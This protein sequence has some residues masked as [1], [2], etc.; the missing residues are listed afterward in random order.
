VR[1]IRLPTLAA[2]AFIGVGCISHG[3]P[4]VGAEANEGTLR[5]CLN[6]DLPPYSVRHGKDGAGFDYLIAE[7]LAKRLGKQ[8]AV[9]WFESKLDEDSSTRIEAN[10][11]LSDGRCDLLGGY[12]LV[13]DELGKPGL[14]TARL[15]GFAGAGAADRRRRVTLGTLAAT[16][17]YHFA[18]LTVVL[19]GKAAAKPITGLADLDGVNIGTEAGTFADAILM[20]F[21]HGR[22][23]SRITHLVPGRGELLPELEKGEYDATLIPLHRFDAY[24]IEHPDTGIKPSGYY[25]RIGFNMGFV[26]LASAA[27]LIERVNLALDDMLKS[28]EPASFAV[29]AHMTYLPP[30]QPFILDDI[31][32]SDLTK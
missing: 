30:R 13:K 24:L 20:S 11:L 31:T 3:V 28:D 4:A 15:P 5:V 9:Q 25:F 18:A 12:P 32:V 10:A 26:G 6:E 16:R 29:A 17:P 14:E 7:S 1:A 22:L 2:A 8:L 19:G 23:I 21:D 27:P